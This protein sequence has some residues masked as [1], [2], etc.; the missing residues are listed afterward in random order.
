MKIFVLLIVITAGY[1]SLVDRHDSV[2]VIFDTGNP[3]DYDDATNLI[4]Q[5]TESN[6]I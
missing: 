6:A 2:A 3:P 1:M 4:K 5:I